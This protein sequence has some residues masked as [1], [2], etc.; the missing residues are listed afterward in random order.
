M[1][2]E[3]LCQKSLVYDK[4]YKFAIRVVNAYKYLT[5]N[6]QEWVLSKQLIRSG[7]SISDQLPVI[8]YQCNNWLIP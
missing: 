5:Q 4:A 7:T 8:S 2:D 3:G 1:S 6:K